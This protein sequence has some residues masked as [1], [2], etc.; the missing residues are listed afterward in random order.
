M[1]EETVE[2]IKKF[3]TKKG[4]K[5]TITDFNQSEIGTWYCRISIYLHGNLVLG[6]NGKGTSKEYALASGFAELYERFSNRFNYVMSPLF[7]RDYIQL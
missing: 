1:P 2:I 6:A 3:F 7:F 5:V 4:F